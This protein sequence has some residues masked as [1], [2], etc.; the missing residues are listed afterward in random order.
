MGLA[1]QTEIC[2]LMPEPGE[3]EL[4]GVQ[5]EEEVQGEGHVSDLCS[6]NGAAS[7]FLVKSN[8]SKINMTYLTSKL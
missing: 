6:V 3:P 5:E 8:L 1:C 2:M 7:S 4:P